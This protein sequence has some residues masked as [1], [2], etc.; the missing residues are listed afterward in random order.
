MKTIRQLSIKGLFLPAIALCSLLLS[1]NAAHA[2][3]VTLFVHRQCHRGQWVPDA[4]AQSHLLPGVGNIRFNSRMIPYPPARKLPGAVETLSFTIGSFTYNLAPGSTNGITISNDEFLVGGIVGDSRL[5]S[6]AHRS[7]DS[8]R[9]CLISTSQ[10]SS[11][12]ALGSSTALQSPPTLDLLSSARW[13]LIFEN[14]DGVAWIQGGISLT[15]VP[16]PA[17]VILFGAGLISLVGLGAGGLRNLRW[18]QA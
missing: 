8:I 15:P 13:R 18:P 9:F 5:P 12:K 10:M 2:T 3:L 14:S 7:M 1:G 17:A 4:D 6:P 11:W 16:L